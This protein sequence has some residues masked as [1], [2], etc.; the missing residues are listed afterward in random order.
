MRL[1]N[2]LVHL[3]AKASCFDVYLLL[4]TLFCYVFKTPTK[5]LINDHI[6]KKKMQKPTELKLRGKIV[7]YQRKKLINHLGYFH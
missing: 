4:I 3:A 6:N 7:T 5:A 1:N 2:K